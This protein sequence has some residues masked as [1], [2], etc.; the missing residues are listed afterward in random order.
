MIINKKRK[1]KI[2]SR[3][4]VAVRAEHR[5]KI[6]ENETRDKYLDLARELKIVVEH[7][8]D[9]DTNSSWCTWNSPQRLGKKTIGIGNQ[10]KNRDH[11]DHSMVEIGQN[12]KKS[13]GDLKRFFITL[14]PVKKN[15]S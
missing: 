12:V 10:R 6:K 2:F 11:A 9:G 8:G 4:D 7:V 5:V 1:K 3:L 15:T 14:I 13:P